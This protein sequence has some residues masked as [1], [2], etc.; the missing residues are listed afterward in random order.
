MLHPFV[1]R[2]KRAIPPKEHFIDKYQAKLESLAPGRF[3]VLDVSDP[4]ERSVTAS[5]I[6]TGVVFTKKF[7]YVVSRLKKNPD[8]VFGRSQDEITEVRDG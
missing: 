2:K 5:N 7:K 4:P 1:V 6:S 8:Q 3:T